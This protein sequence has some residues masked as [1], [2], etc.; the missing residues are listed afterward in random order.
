M[1]IEIFT[2]LSYFLCYQ[3]KTDVLVSI[4]ELRAVDL[5]VGCLLDAPGELLKSLH[6]QTPPSGI[7]IPFVWGSAQALVCF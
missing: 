4:V 7:L 1:E 3:L 2:F 6:A 5:N